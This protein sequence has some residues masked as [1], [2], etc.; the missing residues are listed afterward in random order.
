[1]KQLTKK[2]LSITIALIMV[3]SVVPFSGM[4]TAQATEIW[5]QP[6]GTIITY[7]SY[8]QTLVTDSLTI[9]SLVAWSSSVMWK[10]Y[11]YYTGSGSWYD[12]QMKSSDYMKYKD[13]WYNG[14]RYRAV[15][16]S[17]YR[18]YCTGYTSSASYT[19]QDENGYTPNNVYYFKYEPLRWR[20]LDP[21]EGLVMCE[22]IIDSQA[23]NNYVLY[24][25]GEYW[26]DSAKTYYS[27]NWAKSSLRSW[28]NDDFYNTAFSSSEK[29][30]IKTSYLENKSTYSSVCDAPSTYDKIF[31]LSYWDA[32]NSNYGF[33][34]S[35]SSYDTARRAQGTDYAKCQGLWVSTSSSYYGNSYWRLRSP[36]SSIYTW[37]VDLD[38]IVYTYYNTGYTNYGVRPALKFNPKS[39]IPGVTGVSIG[40]VSLD[41]KSS[42]TIK[43][44]I[45]ADEGASFTVTYTS[46]NPSV[47]TVENNGKV[48]SVKQSGLNRGSTVITCTVTDSNGNTVTDTCTVT[49]N[50]TWWQWIIKIVLF[51]WIWY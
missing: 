43:P 33:S 18:P 32:I 26:G 8:P 29:N 44:T 38:G 47:A 40:D 49:V 35:N 9:T 15:T 51:G 36:H 11:G 46:S 22:S 19:Y 7:G 5:Q 48:T 1:M 24:A 27:S 28:L 10:S 30:A 41:Y 21:S 37:N 50:F 2:L 4:I 12:G 42:A 3:F 20:I 6:A 31:L 23:Y 39:S 45:T 17:K 34:S 25:N 16:F 13:F 14:E